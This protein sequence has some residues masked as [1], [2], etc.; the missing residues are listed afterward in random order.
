MSR[1]VVLDTEA[2]SAVARRERGMAE[3]LEAA[4]RNDQRVVVPS[5]VLAELMTGALR[6]AAIWHLIRR[7][8]VIDI[9]ARIAARAGTLREQAAA[10]RRKKRDLTV[11]SVV[12]S[13]AVTVEPAA[14]VTADP[15]D[16]R[17]LTAGHDVTVVALTR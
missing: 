15:E 3:L 10:N 1:T 17:L 11:D 4:L 12:A 9:D 2:V 8:P 14:V 6:D 13:V 16:F 7:L 5:L